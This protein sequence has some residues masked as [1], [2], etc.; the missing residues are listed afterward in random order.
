MERSINHVYDVAILDCNWR[1][2]EGGGGGGALIH[3]FHFMPTPLANFSLTPILHSY[4]I[5]G[6]SLNVHTKT[7]PALHAT[8]CKAMRSVACE[9]QTSH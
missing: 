9:R 6:H 8:Q 3:F 4:Q 7:T 1:V 5:Q 2:G